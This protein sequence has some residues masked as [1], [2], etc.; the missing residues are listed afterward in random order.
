MDYAHAQ[1]VSNLF[2]IK[3]LGKHH[4]LYVQSDTYYFQIYLKI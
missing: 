4:D 3:N 1:K 2:K